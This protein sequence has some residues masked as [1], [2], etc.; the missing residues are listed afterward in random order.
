MS[1]KLA[2]GQLRFNPERMFIDSRT[3]ELITIRNE[4]AGLF[5]RQPS[6]IIDWA[7]LRGINYPASTPH[8]RSRESS[9]MAGRRLAGGGCGLAWE[10]CMPRLHGQDTDCLLH[11]PILYLLS[12]PKPCSRH[13]FLFF[14]QHFKVQHLVFYRRKRILGREWKEN[15]CICSD[16]KKPEWEFYLD[17][18]WTTGEVFCRTDGRSG[19]FLSC[20]CTK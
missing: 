13:V 2:R 17:E 10:G 14:S 3:F 6:S 20:I 4:K 11:H 7:V 9:H 12:L 16:I 5:I 19:K 1:S 8:L 15:L 18:V